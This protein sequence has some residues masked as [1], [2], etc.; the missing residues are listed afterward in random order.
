VPQGAHTGVSSPDSTKGNISV[1]THSWAPQWH[2][3]IADGAAQP[4]P[5]RLQTSVP[6]AEEVVTTVKDFR[7]HPDPASR[8]ID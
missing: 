8:P 3:R 7:N 5:M 4:S 2:S 1:V 6:R